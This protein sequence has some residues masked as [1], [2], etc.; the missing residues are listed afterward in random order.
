MSMSVIPLTKEQDALLKACNAFDGI[1]VHRSDW[2]IAK[3]L[4]EAEHAD[5]LGPA[6]GPERAWRRLYP[7]KDSR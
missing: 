6:R 5:S 4:V 1:E 3:A 2:A 7:V